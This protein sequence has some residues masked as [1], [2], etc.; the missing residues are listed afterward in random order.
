M[1]KVGVRALKQNASAVVRGVVAGERVVITDRGRAVAQLTALPTSPL[2]TLRDAGLARPPR[3][4][5]E[6]LPAPAPGPQISETLA[7]MR[8]E[9]PY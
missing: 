6:D 9:E 2:Q 7:Q 4:R 5:I 1:A 8:D 3:G